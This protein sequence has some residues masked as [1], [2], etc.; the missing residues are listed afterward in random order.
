MSGLFEDPVD[1]SMVGPATVD[2][3]LEDQSMS[4]GTPELITDDA[5]QT[6]EKKH[7]TALGAHEDARA[8]VRLIQCYSCS[9]PFHNPV[10]LPCG[11]SI[12][13]A[14]VPPTYQREGVSYPDTPGRRRGFLC[15]ECAEEHTLADCSIDVTLQKLMEAISQLV[16]THSAAAGE[17]MQ[18]YVEEV[19]RKDEERLLRETDGKPRNWIRPGGRLTATYSLSDQGILEYERDVIYQPLQEAD[20]AYRKLDETFLSQ[21]IE[22]A[23]K[24]LDCQVCYNLMCDPVTTAC[25][26]TLC[27]KCL[28]RTLDHSLHCPVCR[29]HVTIPPSLQGHPSNKTLVNLL[30]GLCPDLVAA[31]RE[32]VAAE[33]AIGLGDMDTPLFVCT[34]A[35]PGSP[36]FLRV[37]EP[38]YRLMIR[39]AMSA[40]QQFG[41]LMYNSRGAPQGDLGPVHFC[42]YGTM[43]R[44]VN[45]QRLPDGQSIIEAVGIGRFRVKSHGMLDGYAI[46][47]VERVEDL[48]IAE[49]ERME[50]E[51]TALPPADDN[52]VEGQISRMSTRQLLM[53]G[54]EFILKMQERSAPWL[55]Q[56]ILDAYGGPPDDASFFPYW[57]ASILPIN[58]DAKYVLLQTNSVRQRLKIT[59]L[60]IKQM[61]SQRWY[62]RGISPF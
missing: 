31:R 17:I 14:C 11:N 50:A 58:D 2:D 22:L 15:L 30:N 5:A 51:E 39:R 1:P 28:V 23:H 33:E 18:T 10:T 43:L 55:H 52:D 3:S 21:L 36:T 19:L 24:E 45:V 13:R 56:R 57:L 4:E 47:N 6:L 54:L 34:L 44:I 62:V 26:H 61:E 46:G 7:S 59:A 32:A 27:R 60:W 53:L 9:K 37:F 8:L 41:M 20:D 25:G 12:C 40:N 49:E 38:R 35:F 42:E 48:G 16:D 29:R